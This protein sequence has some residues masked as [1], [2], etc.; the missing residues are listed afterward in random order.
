MGWADSGAVLKPDVLRNG[1]LHSQA[2]AWNA[3]AERYR[4]ELQVSLLIDEGN[5]AQGYLLLVR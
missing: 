3:G 1:K 5:Q 2:L 4:A